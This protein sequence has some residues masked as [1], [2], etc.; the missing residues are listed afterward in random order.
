MTTSVTP[1]AASPSS[2]TISRVSLRTT[3]YPRIRVQSSPESVGA[4]ATSHP[5]FFTLRLLITMRTPGPART[6]SAPSTSSVPSMTTSPARVRALRAVTATRA[7]LATRALVWARVVAKDG[8]SVTSGGSFSGTPAH[9][10]SVPTVGTSAPARRRKWQLTWRASRS[11]VP[12]HSGGRF[13]AAFAAA[14]AM[15]FLTGEKQTQRS[16]CVKPTLAVAG[17]SRGKSCIMHSSRVALLKA[18]TAPAGPSAYLGFTNSFTRP[19]VWSSVAV[20]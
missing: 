14:S 12:A 16:S 5:S 17:R 10:P 20:Y 1:A 3:E 6:T 2:R 18:F 13:F 4:V 19:P 8:R 15:L 7:P 11:A 9:V